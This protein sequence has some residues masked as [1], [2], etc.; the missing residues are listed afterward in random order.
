[1]CI[2]TDARGMALSRERLGLLCGIAGPA[3]FLAL[4]SI[5]MAG[6]PEYVFFR[7]YLSD[8]GV[9]EAAWAFNSAVI[10]A[11][12]LC[13]PFILLGVRPNLD[14]GVAA[15]LG[16]VAATVGCAFLVLVG[17]F[18]EDYDPTH[19]IVS[20]GFFASMLAALGFMSWSLHF[21]NS[22]G[23]VATGVTGSAFVVGS[24]VMLFGFN[25]WT[26]TV[27]V[28]LIIVWAVSLAV[29]LLRQEGDAPT[30]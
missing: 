12:L 29:L 10:M 23:K 21:S 16:V 28:L 3:V 1:L 27:A 7:N 30:S 26:E 9:G 20:I 18:T 4:Y 5:A 13:F 14:G 22:M 11:G 24:V 6:D 2:H 8:L 15:T 25:P 19:F 17:V